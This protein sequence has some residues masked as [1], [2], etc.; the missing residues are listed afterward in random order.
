M[1]LQYEVALFSCGMR[2]G[3]RRDANQSVQLRRLLAHD[4]AWRKLKWTEARPFAHLAGSFHP[5]AVSGS[6]IAFIPFGG[7]GPV[8]GFRLLI[9]QFPSLLRGIEMRHWELQFQLISVHDTLMD[10]SQDLLILLEPDSLCVL[11]IV[12]VVGASC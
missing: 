10:V 2:D 4:L 3:P 12:V 9:Q 5:T 7:P 8:S 11:I 1:Q 6:T